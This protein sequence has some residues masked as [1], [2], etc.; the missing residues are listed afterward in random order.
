M[1]TSEFN[2]F[3]TFIAKW[4]LKKVIN[5]IQVG[6]TVLDF[7]CGSQAYLLNQVRSKIKRGVGLDYEISNVNAYENIF[8]Q[9]FCFIDKMPFKCEF[10]KITMLAVL[11]HIELDIIDSIFSEFNRILKHGGEILMTTPT[12]T[13]KILL[14]FLAFKLKIISQH[15]IADHKKYYSRRDVIEIAQRFGFLLKKYKTFQLGCNSFFIFKK[16]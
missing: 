6:D 13:G 9:S 12:P 8:L 7:G 4:R 1:G 15:Q 10:D 14:E 2:I 5:H 16:M 11:E 3:D